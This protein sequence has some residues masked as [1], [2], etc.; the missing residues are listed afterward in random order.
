MFSGGSALKS[1]PK[2]PRNAWWLCVQKIEG[3]ADLNLGYKNSQGKITP[4]SNSKQSAKVKIPWGSV[5]KCEYLLT[6][7]DDGT[8][9]EFKFTNKRGE[10]TRL[11]KAILNSFEGGVNLFSKRVTAMVVEKK[12][13]LLALYLSLLPYTS[14][15]LFGS[16]GEVHTEDGFR[17]DEDGIKE[18]DLVKNGGSLAEFQDFVKLAYESAEDVELPDPEKD[19]SGDISKF[20]LPGKRKSQN[21]NSRAPKKSKAATID[22]NEQRELTDEEG[23]EKEY[24]N[25]FVGMVSI[26]LD[27]ISISEDL[28]IKLCQFRVYKIVESIQKKY[29]PSQSIPV[30]CP[31]DDQSAIDLKNVEKKKYMVVQKI[32][33]VSAFKELNKS[34]KFGQLPSH[35]KKTVLCFVIKSCKT[36][37]IHY[38]NL[39]ANEISNNFARKKT[40]PQDFLRI[41]YSLCSKE[42][43]ENSLKVIERMA[44]LS[45]LGPN[46]SSALRKIC[47]W[48][49]QAFAALMDVLNQYE[50]YETMDVKPKGHAQALLMGEKMAITNSV[51]KMLAKVDETYFVAVHRKI[52]MNKC[53]LQS[54]VEDYNTNKEVEKVSSVLSILAGFKDIE[55]IRN[56]HPG[57]FESNQL[58]SYIGADIINGNP[59]DQAKKMKKYYHSVV[60]GEEEKLEKISFVEYEKLE[61][62]FVKEEIKTSGIIIFQMKQEASMGFV[63]ELIRRSTQLD[64]D[65]NATLITF[66][67]EAFQFDVLSFLRSHA[68]SKDAKFRIVPLLFHGNNYIKDGVVENVKFAVLFGKFVVLSPPLNVDHG[69]ISNLNLVVNKICPPGSSVAVISDINVPL[70]KIHSEA[71]S[72][73]ITYIGGRKEMKKFEASLLKRS[74]VFD[75]EAADEPLEN[76]L[77]EALSNVDENFNSPSSSLKTGPVSSPSQSSSSLLFKEKLSVYDFDKHEK[78]K[79]DHFDKHEE[80]R[81]DDVGDRQEELKE[82]LVNKQEEVKEDHDDKQKDVKDNRVDEEE[83]V[84]EDHVN[85]QEEKK[86]DQSIKA[87]QERYRH[88]IRLLHSC[89]PEEHSKAG[90]VE[91]DVIRKYFMTKEK[92]SP[93]DSSEINASIDKMADEKKV[94]RKGDTVFFL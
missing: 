62:I 36:G 42:N 29:D 5:A 78:E 68:K 7:F 90:S 19:P 18:D 94:M 26:P 34:G 79:G 60:S 75:I 88:F 86:E 2:R 69:S 65:F 53:S 11:K 41:F 45:R 58:I 1:S 66:P 9:G 89:C 28:K 8:V 33:L 24:Q 73:N 3:V 72:A 25:S 61:N 35:S 70:V 12:E 47:G 10:V 57:R 31:A 22:E 76:I 17:L 15:F 84:K 44:K 64:E 83:E 80:D 46:E 4:F 27:N 23:L 63:A 21:P 39:R 91:L 38:G 50:R 16:D 67:T 20:F 87:D 49:S 13:G 85:K 81:E 30:V 14:G 92:S 54:C 6:R 59:N 77:S 52:L 40:A 82:V 48:S 74:R 32:H 55:D 37:L 71:L 93:F 56:E 51:F 43:S